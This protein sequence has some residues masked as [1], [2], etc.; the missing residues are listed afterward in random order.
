MNAAVAN[1]DSDM[2]TEHAGELPLHRPVH[3][4]NFPLGEATR[5]TTDPLGN[6]NTQTPEQSVPLTETVPAPSPPVV[7]IVRFT[8]GANLAVTVLLADTLTSQVVSEPQDG[9]D[10]FRSR[11]PLVGIAVRV[12]V[13]SS[14]KVAEHCEPQLI[15]PELQTVPDPDLSTDKVNGTPN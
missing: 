4:V 14:E 1:V 9:S 8:M 6:G 2:L 15:E 13:V 3:V 10:Q 5:D 7:E 12:T 11:Y